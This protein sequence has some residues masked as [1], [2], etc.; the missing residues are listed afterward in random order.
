MLKK[1]LFTFIAYVLSIVYLHA[2]EGKPYYEGDYIRAVYFVFTNP[3]ADSLAQ[4][5]V[6]VEVQRRFPVYAG[7]TLRFILLD[8][9]L[10][11][12]EQL[13]EIENAS[14]ELRPVQSGEVEVILTLKLSGVAI[15]KSTKGGYIHDKTDFPNLYRDNKN[16]LTTKINVSQ[17][18]Y[19]NNDAWYGRED[20]MLNGNPLSDDP[21]GKGF[22]GWTEGWVSAGLYG[23]T[24]VSAKNSMYLYGGASYIVSGSAGR[25]LFTD[26]ARVH[27]GFDDAYLGFLGTKTYGNGDRLT[28]NISAGR[29]QFSIGKGFIIRNT[30]ANG[31]NRAALQLNPR[32]ASDFLGLFSVKYNNLLLQLFHIDPDE[33]PVVDSKTIIRGVNTEW[34]HSSSALLGFSVLHVPRS[35]SNYFT[36][37]G[38][39]LGR[40]GL[41]L[42]NLR[43]YGNRP[44]GV[45]GLLYKAEI[46]YERN[47]N[48]SMGA[49]A[50]YGETGWDF[51]K[52]KGAPVLT[53][54]FAYFSGDDPSTER[55]ER[56]DPL[57]TGGNGEEWVLGANHFKIVQNSN[58]VVHKLQLSYRLSSKFQIVPQLLFMSAAQQNNIG[59]NPALSYMPKKAYGYE[60][61]VSWK[62]FLSRRWYVHGHLAYTAPGA[63]VQEALTNTR[64]WFSAMAFFRYSIF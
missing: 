57:L 1:G 30:A 60:A 2:Q 4:K 13:P 56:W 63:G 44:P 48:F 27:G 28:Y 54:R 9:Y 22:T 24:T 26:K 15:K 42:Y 17:M 6:L 64:S 49:W 62:Y 40:E 23:I 8:A 25:E 7:W 12:V 47:A 3:L 52:A 33:L 11:R 20:E 29:Q 35:E 46:A 38:K 34:G 45:P 58:M 16:L 50:G 39:V 21:A 14:Y 61:N 32:W 19:A 10:V 53:Y 5:N 18:V 55:F 59:G 51:S 41:W 43:Y 31:D 37:A 36:P